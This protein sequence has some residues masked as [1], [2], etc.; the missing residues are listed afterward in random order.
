MLMPRTTCNSYCQCSMIARSNKAGTNNTRPYQFRDTDCIKM[1][2]EKLLIHQLEDSNI[3][4]IAIK[5]Y[6]NERLSTNDGLRLY[7]DF[8]LSD[9]SLLASFVK[10]KLNGNHVFY[11]KNIHLEPTNIC[12]YDCKFCSYSRKL[13]ETGS[14]DYSIDDI[15]QIARDFQHKDIT[16][17]HITGGVHPDKDVYDYGKMI[18]EI[19]NIL[20]NVSIKAFTPIEIRYMCKKSGLSVPQGLSY[21]KSCG[22][23]AMPGG[24]AEIFHAEIRNKICPEKGPAEIWL[25][26]HKTAHQ[27]GIP[28]NATMLYGHVESYEH[29]VD[30][31]LKIR[32][33]QDE[34]NGFNAFIPL[35]YRKHNNDM[36]EVGELPMIEDLR[37]Y[38]VSR[39][40]LDNIPHLKAYWPMIGKSTAKIALSFG[41]DDLDGTIDD[42]TKIYTMAG[43]EETRPGMTTGEIRRLISHAN[44]KPVER[45]TFYNPVKI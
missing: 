23:Q 44:Y 8:G 29:R 2:A 30:H 14:W 43:S 6:N 37:N 34:T 15:I 9:L 7:N 40:F 19:K 31:L 26:T 12:I 25:E 3:N 18:R 17:V 38:A 33:I 41:V 45:D 32:E 16:E 42:T 21:L 39:I 35:K 28:S 36:F 5:V 24:G 27:L 10:E 13:G 11:N 1:N 22:L 4:D 20:P